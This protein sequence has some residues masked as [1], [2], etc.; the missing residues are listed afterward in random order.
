M[1]HPLTPPLGPGGFQ[2]A[3][4]AR[5]AGIHLLLSA[6]VA[7]LAALLVFGL[8]YPAPFREISGGRE[9]FFI[10][11]AVDVVLGPLITFSVFDRRKPWSELRRDLA[12]VGL[13]QLGGLAYGLHTVFVARPVVLA[14]EGQ[15]LRVLRAIDLDAA[16]LAKAPADLQHLPLHGIRVVAAREL[17]T[18]ERNQAIDMALGGVDVG[19]RPE[20]WLPP[21][22]TPAAL[23]AA[24]KPVD[25]LARRYPQRTDELARFVAATGRT[26]AHLKFLPLLARRTDWVAFIDAAS[27]AIVG[28]APFDGF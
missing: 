20:L 26:A 14:G 17:N 2:I 4:R 28:Y 10:I 22:R 24:A 12:V 5:A 21:E 27:G 25:E 23:V 6:G 18:E 9:L 1:Q 19:M 8:W 15:R 13:L 11:I 3:A 16:A 7:G